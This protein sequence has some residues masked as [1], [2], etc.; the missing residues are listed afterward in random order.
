MDMEE[1]NRLYTLYVKPLERE[2]TGEY[3]AVTPDGRIVI[4]PTLLDTVE[5]AVST[6]GPGNVVFKVG[7]RG[8]EVAVPGDQVVSEHFP[9]LPIRL[10]VAGRSIAT[11]ALLDT[12][13]DGAVVMPDDFLGPDVSPDSH[14]PWTL[15]D[16]S[17]V[18]APVCVDMLRIGDLEPL[19][20]VITALGREMLVGRTVSDRFR[21]TL[22]HGRRL[23]L[24][25]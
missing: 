8:R 20:V 23:I 21:I 17:A 5:E 9:Y 22:E 3:A 1:A 10:L 4:G 2:H 15:A 25:P 12:G 11:E 24:E 16:G 19:R 7:E 13:F 18:L 14:A 6:P